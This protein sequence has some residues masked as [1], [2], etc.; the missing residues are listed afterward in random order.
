MDKEYIL[1]WFQFADTDIAAAEYLTKM[2]PQPFEIIC[3]HCQQSA[4][5]YLKGYLIYNG[6]EEPPKIHDLIKLCNLCSEFNAE[7]DSI[8]KLCDYLTDFGI[9]PRYPDEME[10][11]AQNMEKALKCANEIKVFGPL[12]EVREKL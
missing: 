5:K 2:Y 11:T 10:I 1:H 9:Q 8:L 12:A 4:E 6:I 3:Y 7:F